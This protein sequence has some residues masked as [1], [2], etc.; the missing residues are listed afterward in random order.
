MLFGV[1]ANKR[2][3]CVSFQLFVTLE[4]E[5]RGKKKKRKTICSVNADQ[6]ISLSAVTKKKKKRCLWTQKSPARGT[7]VTL[8]LQA[9]AAGYFKLK[10][11]C[12][13]MALP[14][15]EGWNRAEIFLCVCVRTTVAG[16]KFSDLKLAMPHCLHPSSSCFAT[17][18][19]PVSAVHG[20]EDGGWV[21]G[22]VSTCFPC[23]PFHPDQYFWESGIFI[24]I[25][26][27]GRSHGT[28][29]GAVWMFPAWAAGIQHLPAVVTGRLEPFGAFPAALVFSSHF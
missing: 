8:L 14:G 16:L 21:F 5:R 15:L 2:N 10:S 9:G 25:N 19:P 23:L 13:E 29:F 3:Y 20:G 7:S 18:F 17:L 28:F 24:C 4:G 6:S 27:G 11:A 12:W 26:W 1:T 22:R